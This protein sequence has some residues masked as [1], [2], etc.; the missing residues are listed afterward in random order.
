LKPPYDFRE[1]GFKDDIGFPIQTT[2]PH[3]VP[4]DVLHPPAAELA[5]RADHHGPVRGRPDGQRAVNRGS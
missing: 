2:G 1:I 5:V 4:D 3:M